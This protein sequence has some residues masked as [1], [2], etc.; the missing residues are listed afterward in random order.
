MSPPGAAITGVWSADHIRSKFSKE[1]S[2]ISISDLPR[3]RQELQEL[4]D[5]NA[6]QHYAIRYIKE[7]V[8]N[9]KSENVTVTDL[10]VNLTNAVNSNGDKMDTCNSKVDV[11]TE[12]FERLNTR[13]SAT[14]H[15]IGVTPSSDTMPV[16]FKS[17]KP[18]LK[19]VMTYNANTGTSTLNP[20]PIQPQV[21]APTP[22]LPITG[23]ISKTSPAVKLPAPATTA[24]TIP[25]PNSSREP[26][27]Y[28]RGGINYAEMPTP[29]L[30]DLI[31]H[32]RQEEAV[33][34]HLRGLGIA[35]NQHKTGGLKEGCHR[36]RGAREG[37]PQQA[38]GAEPRDGE[39][40]GIGPRRRRKTQ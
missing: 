16:P 12:N 32:M 23:A 36:L 20:P 13:V 14:E 11:L 18:Q 26:P 37:P 10:L 24:S 3:I 25:V 22:T 5:T 6:K 29:H 15:H 30:G 19:G 28:Y 8:E 21:A 7:Y 40:S 33:Q 34:K 27:V 38:G 31:E 35:T 4:A 2:Q 1:K 39:A 9:N 17:Y